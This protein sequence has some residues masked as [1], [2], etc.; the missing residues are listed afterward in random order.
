M[1]VVDALNKRRAILFVA[2]VSVVY[3]I[4]LATWLL[5]HPMFIGMDFWAYW[6]AAHQ[7]PVEAYAPRQAVQ[8]PY[9]PT[10][11]IWLAPLRLASYGFARAAFI[12]TSTFAFALA[13]RP[14]LSRSQML[15]A[16]ASPPIVNGICAGQCSIAL[17]ATL[18]WACGA[19]NRIAAG[20]ALGLIASVKPQLVIMA[21]ALLLVRRDWPAF[22]AAATT[23]LVMVA[24]SL[25]F[26]GVATWQAWLGSLS[27]FHSVL[28]MKPR[29]AV[30]LS[31]AFAAAQLNLPALPFWIAGACVGLW[32]IWVARRS[33]PL[34]QCGAIACASL[35]SAPYSLVYDLAPTIP[36]LTIAVWSGSLIAAVAMSG[37][38]APISLILAAWEIDAADRS[39]KR[40]AEPDFQSQPI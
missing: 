12:L 14:Y 13:S 16:I 15:L 34:T 3:A 5:R 4:G 38:L 10:M 26:F 25:A 17:G 29:L 8:F 35:L 11:L 7:S 28:G 1:G 6:R 27:Y 37:V 9:L 22:S 40:A 18:L 39:R 32:L 23:W 33:A 20:I 30:T 24:L 2:L 36:F 19:R 31:P 21:P